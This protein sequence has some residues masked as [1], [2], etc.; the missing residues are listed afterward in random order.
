MKT[1]K[2]TTCHPDKKHFG[3]GLCKPCH[4][5]KYAKDHPKRMAIAKNKYAKIN[6][7]K[8]KI[9]NIKWVKSNPKKVA[10]KQARWS[11]ANPEK[12]SA[13]E[14]K[15]RAAKNRRVPKWADL[16]AIRLF[17]INCPTGYEVDHIF[18]LQGKTVSG[19]HTLDNLQY[20]TPSKNRHWGN[21]IKR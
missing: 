21:R 1:I 16:E 12:R 17:Y 4:S 5:K 14:A 20:L 9:A 18:P 13:Y 11:R 3:N 15:R 19:L 7:E 8:I 6:P 2:T 10:A